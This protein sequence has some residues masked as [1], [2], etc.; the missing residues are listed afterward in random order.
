MSLSDKA[1]EKAGGRKKVPA[2]KAAKKA[3]E[4]VDDAGGEKE[5]EAAFGAEPTWRGKVLEPFSI[6]RESLFHQQRL[7]AG[8]PDFDQVLQAQGND[9]FLADAVR[10]LY[11]CSHTPEDWRAVRSSPMTMQEAI[12]EWAEEHVTVAERAEAVRVGIQIFNLAWKQAPE[13]VSDGVGGASGN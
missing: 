5:R 12:D 10:I 4:V 7:G 13:A 1:P 6:S 8:A 3:P 2:K 11:L 9:A